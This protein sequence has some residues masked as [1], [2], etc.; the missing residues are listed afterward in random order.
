MM[1]KKQSAFRVLVSFAVVFS[2][3][4]AA[5]QTKAAS[6]PRKK[7]KII[8][9]KVWNK[10]RIFIK[11]GKKYRF[12]AKGKWVDLTTKTDAKGYVS[13]NFILKKSERFR[14]MR[15]AKWFSLICAINR[16][17]KK[18]LDV[19]K[20]IDKKDG[21]YHSKHTGRLFC[22]ANDVR[23]MYWNN[24]GTIRLTVVEIQE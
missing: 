21:I 16:N 19:G 9:R 4:M 3:V 17:P 12:M 20:I 11:K 5:P 7:A 14:R 2:F 1:N 6:R 22:F 18:K 15:S 13:P 10:T 24:K 8:A 23:T